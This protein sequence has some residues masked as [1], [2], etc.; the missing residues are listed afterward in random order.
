[1]TPRRHLSRASPGAGSQES[2]HLGSGA[3]RGRAHR[4][5]PRH[6]PRGP[7]PSPASGSA[8]SDSAAT[9]ASGSGAALL[10]DRKRDWGWS[11]AP[12]RC[13]I[14]AR[15][16]ARQAHLARGGCRRPP[17][18][19]GISLVDPTQRGS[20]HLRRRRLRRQRRRW[21]RAAVQEIRGV[22]IGGGGR[23]GGGGT[24][25]AS[26]CDPVAPRLVAAAAAAAAAGGCE[27]VF[28]WGR[29]SLQ[30]RGI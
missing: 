14:G 15:G 2:L 18:F 8:A 26:E 10:R 17:A 21:G 6:R 1:M 19:L 5:P 11:A 13:P 12:P 25:A 16:Q 24:A 4:P 9:A 30:A 20:W 23:V 7:S 22:G 28:P 27:A 3:C 29:S